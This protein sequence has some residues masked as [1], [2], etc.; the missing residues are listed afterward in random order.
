VAMIRYFAY[1]SNMDKDD[2]DAW[3]RAKSKPEISSAGASPAVLRDFRL[4]FNYY[5]E[6]RGGGAANIM[7]SLGDRVCGLLLKITETDLGVIRTK[8]VW[9][10]HYRE[11]EID[12][13]TLTGIV[14][15]NVKT[16]KV[17]KALERPR[18]QPPTRHY[19]ELII[20]AARR[21]RFPAEYVEYLESIEVKQ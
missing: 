12:V 4:C 1:G 3:C 5:A 20:R 17:V 16:F 2:L 13:E 7:E 9:P 14:I 15:P 18:H 6:S 10:S 19:M 21:Y 8:E 11:I